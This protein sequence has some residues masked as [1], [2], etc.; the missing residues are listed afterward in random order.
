M[1]SSEQKETK[2]Q[3]G[4]HPLEKDAAQVLPAL[5]PDGSRDPSVPHMEGGGLL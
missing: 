1:C 2:A 4:H 5:P 3:E